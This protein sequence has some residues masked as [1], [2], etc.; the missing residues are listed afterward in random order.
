MLCE[1]KEKEGLCELNKCVSE[2]AQLCAGAA[3]DITSVQPTGS[4]DPVP[5]NGGSRPEQGFAG[6]CRIDSGPCCQRPERIKG[7]PRM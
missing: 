3:V 6:R 5:G 7:G 4:G 1:D 2:Q